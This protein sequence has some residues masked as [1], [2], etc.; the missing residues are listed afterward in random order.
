MTTPEAGVWEAQNTTVADVERQLGRI[1]RE[2]T[3]PA[4]NGDGAHPLP[5][6]SVLNLLVHADEEGEAERAAAAMASLAVRH[7]S[8]TLLL[9]TAA[10]AAADG[11]D[12]AIRVQRAHRQGGLGHLCF[13]QVRL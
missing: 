2:L 4:E 9:V 8:R 11:L 5:R 3:L 1:L 7:P 6:A 12:A 13:E 10:D